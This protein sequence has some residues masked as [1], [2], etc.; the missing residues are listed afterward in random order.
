[1][2]LITYIHTY[3]YFLIFVFVEKGT[4][5][6]NHIHVYVVHIAEDEREFDYLQ[7][8]GK[9][10]KQWGEMKKEWAACKNGVMQSP[11]DL[12]SQRVKLIPNLGKLNTTY[13][14]CNATVKNRGHD[15]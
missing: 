4:K 3:S 13:K 11:I 12:S 2:R 14:P 15:I 6:I 9:G 10:P 7:G 8:S 1:M 5:L